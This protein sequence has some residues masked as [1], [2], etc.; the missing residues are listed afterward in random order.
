M[1]VEEKLVDGEFMEDPVLFQKA[2]VI[3]KETVFSYGSFKDFS[4][5]MFTLEKLILKLANETLL[6]MISAPE[7]APSDTFEANYKSFREL[8]TSV[9]CGPVETSRLNSLFLKSLEQLLGRI[10]DS[11]RTVCAVRACGVV[12]HFFVIKTV[13]ADESYH[14][15]KIYSSDNDSLFLRF[16]L[17]LYDLVSSRIDHN[18]FALISQLFPLLIQ[19]FE[20]FQ[21]KPSKIKFY[22]KIHSV[23]MKITSKV[24]TY[25]T[26][27]L[28]GHFTQLGPQYFLCARVFLN[29]ARL[30]RCRDSDPQ[31]SQI[32]RD[33][34]TNLRDL[35]IPKFSEQPRPV[36]DPCLYRAIHLISDNVTSLMRLI[37][38][39]K[40]SAPSIWKELKLLVSL[41]LETDCSREMTQELITDHGLP[42]SQFLPPETPD[43]R[44]QT[45]KAHLL[46][47][48]GQMTKLLQVGI[49]SSFGALAAQFFRSIMQFLLI[50]LS[51]SSVS[52]SSTS[53]IFKHYFPSHVESGS[54]QSV[55][56]DSN[57]VMNFWK[58]DKFQPS[59][60]FDVFN[61][62]LISQTEK[63]FY[64][65]LVEFESEGITREEL[66]QRLSSPATKLALIRGVKFIQNNPSGSG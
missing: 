10:S 37:T 22:N 41:L 44:G 45:N 58:N 43:S 64:D 49:D 57:T 52:V 14:S 5:Y 32:V 26:L 29:R 53:P 47:I 20:I 13:H 51:M 66:R 19:K 2:M 38:K 1:L 63:G 15:G 25:L 56:A 48:H 16:H 50:P 4:T 12:D 54:D 17:N 28:R 7:S 24:L 34:Y 9:F 61:K 11:S 27:H 8:L 31:L 35:L 33:F 39:Q 3:F 62:E 21:T 59:L 36:V 42:L 30:S 6:Q 65:F 18:D 60:F 55:D 23:Q 40:I 46:L